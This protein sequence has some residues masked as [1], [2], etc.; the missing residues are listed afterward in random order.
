M[1][2]QILFSELRLQCRQPLFLTLL[3]VAPLFGYFVG[4]GISASQEALFQRFHLQQ[5][6][7]S[8][9]MMA[10][11]WV[12]AILGVAVLFRDQLSGM[13]ELTQALP[14]ERV[15]LQGKIV[16]GLVISIYALS[17]L[18]VCGLWAGLLAQAQTLPS[19]AELVGVLLYIQ[20]LFLVLSLPALLLLLSVYWFLRNLVAK[21]IVIYLTAL[22]VF[23]AYMALSSASGSPLMAGSLAPNPV[24]NEVW[25]YLDWFGLTAT[26]E[27]DIDWQVVLLNRAIVLLVTG[28]FAMGAI[29]SVQK[30]FQASNKATTKAHKVSS[31]APV[32]RPLLRFGFVSVTASSILQFMALVRL[33]SKQLLLG[34][35][36]LFL[37]FVWMSI[38]VSEIYPSL[39]FAEIGATLHGLSIDAINRIMWDLL[40]LF[41]SALMLFL[42][43]SLVWRDHHSNFALVSEALP[44]PFMVRLCSHLVTL[45]TAL[46]YF[47]ILTVVAAVISQLLKNS[48]VQWIEYSYF[49]IFAGIPLALKGVTFIA[50][51][52]LFKQR[53]IAVGLC[54]TILL[55]EFTP[56]PTLVGLTHPLFS[57]FTT[58]LNASDVML[59]YTAHLDGFV[60]FSLFWLMASLTMV[61]LTTVRNILEP[62]LIRQAFH[63]ALV[64]L[65]FTLTSLQGAWI[66]REL[67]KDGETLVSSDL[68]QLLADY[69]RNYKSFAAMPMPVIDE[70][71]TD[72]AIFPH[73]RRVLINGTY[74]LSNPHNKPIDTILIG[75]SWRTPLMDLQLKAPSHMTHDKEQGQYVFKLTDTLAPGQHINLQF[76][77]Q[78][79]QSGYQAIP[80]HKV[81]TSDFV[82]LRAM[83]YFPEVGYLPIR[84]ISNNDF[85]RDYGLTPRNKVSTEEQLKERDTGKDRYDWAKLTTLISTPTG[86]QTFSQG[87]LVDEWVKGERVYRKF[88]TL[89]PVRRIQAFVAT[90]AIITKHTFSNQTLQVA[91][92]PQH[93]DNVELTLAAM[94]HTTAFL[95]EAMGSFPGNTLTL[96]EAPDLGPSGYALPQLILIGS[97]TGFRARQDDG[98]PFSHAY[99]RAVHETAHQWFGHLLGN[100]VEEDSS[101][102][103]ESMAKYVELVMLERYY[104]EDAMQALVD[105]ERARYTH[106]ERFNS[107]EM[108][109]L[110]SAQSPHDSYSRATLVFAQ[111]RREISDD[112]ILSALSD[113]ATEHRYPQRPASSLDFVNALLERAPQD[114]ELIERLLIKPVPV[115]EE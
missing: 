109:S 12:T 115:I 80:A 35:G 102:L 104:G 33:S 79:E 11:P 24:F 56:L 74:K 3:I 85:R 110:I 87:E 106:A 39:H 15:K 54:L 73:K 66:Q 53:I 17:V 108:V 30:P 103:V 105:Y 19:L 72:V 27:K 91:H 107:E 40:P 21:S 58:P 22:I 83:P 49:V 60:A 43:Y 82:Y 45:L 23:V 16:V 13:T 67:I 98:Q 112:V 6:T 9:S 36:A 10:L 42:S 8:L 59:G 100:G 31:N 93:S 95:T 63:L 78:M 97:R 57:L 18:A 2:Y 94:E 20:G 25:G 89:E 61:S 62:T 68:L 99:R 84:E 47:L 64:A 88:A 77:M 75:E 26:F 34:P 48:T 14:I 4:Q 46:G 55:F 70:V 37:G 81:L 96:I 114:R 32:E 38:V 28:L 44:V 76:S 5:V 69:E 52:T 71:S 51:F 65:F 101:F 90:R 29:K 41:G 92:L 86:F 113:I 1:F 50:I 7:G 111:L